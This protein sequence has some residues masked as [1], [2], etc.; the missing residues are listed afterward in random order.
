[1]VRD[2]QN[3]DKKVQ[4][5]AYVGQKAF[6][7]MMGLLETH[8]YKHILTV[9]SSSVDHIT[10]ALHVVGPDALSYK[11]DICRAFCN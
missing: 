4:L 6:W 7:L 1:M 9:I 2:K 3:S 11:V 10:Q 8:T 5:R